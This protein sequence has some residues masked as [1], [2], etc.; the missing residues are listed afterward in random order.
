MRKLKVDGPNQAQLSSESKLN[1]YSNYTD[2]FSCQLREWELGEDTV[3]Y[4]PSPLSF[5]HIFNK[6]K[7]INLPPLAPDLSIKTARVSLF[8]WLTV[9][10]PSAG[11]QNGSEVLYTWGTSSS[12]DPEPTR[13]FLKRLQKFRNFKMFL[14]K[15]KSGSGIQR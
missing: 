9:P 2:Q 11:N 3:L 10:S 13:F 1:Q 5:I 6:G 14:N 7:Q 4:A 8:H 15:D 12:H